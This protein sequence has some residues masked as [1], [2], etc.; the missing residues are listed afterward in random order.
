M[1]LSGGVETKLKRQNT[2]VH[3]P[4]LPLLA[5]EAL[6]RARAQAIPLRLT[7]VRTSQ[8]L[9]QGWMVRSRG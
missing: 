7:V 5:S 3:Q 8:R 6:W 4:R 2:S 9:Q 1:G